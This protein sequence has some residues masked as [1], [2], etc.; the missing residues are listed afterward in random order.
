MTSWPEKLR[1][2]RERIAQNSA[3]DMA[4]VHRLGHIG[5]TEIDHDSLGRCRL[6]HAESLVSAESRRLFS[7]R[8]SARSVKL[9]KPAPAI[10]GGSHNITD[11][12]MFNNLL[13]DLLRILPT[14]FGEHECGIGL[15]IAETWIGR[16]R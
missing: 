6:G 16:R 5:R 4:D 11:I 3:A 10:V 1:D 9:I 2:P 12:E 7:P 14:L 13:R 8:A 15:I